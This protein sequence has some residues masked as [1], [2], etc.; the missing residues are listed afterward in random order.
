MNGF[1]GSDF[2]LDPYTYS[3]WNS[4]YQRNHE[5]PRSY[6]GQYTTDVMQEKALGLLDDALGSDSPFFLTVAPIAPH[7]NIDVE[8][9]DAGAPKMTEPLPAPR[10]A[11][12]FADAKVPRTPNFNPLEVCDGMLWWRQ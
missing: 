1:N 10:H 2:L 5:P 9:G 6:E 8:S 11:H 12:L 7:T 3:Y 4:T